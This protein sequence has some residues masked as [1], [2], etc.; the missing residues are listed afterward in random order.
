LKQ[1]IR[2]VRRVSKQRHDIPIDRWSYRR[3]WEK[4]CGRL[5]SFEA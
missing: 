4:S 5:L 3:P 2:E 1:K